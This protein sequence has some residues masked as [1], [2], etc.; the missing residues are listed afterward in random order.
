MSQLADRAP[1]CFIAESFALSN[2]QP[3]LVSITEEELLRI[4]ASLPI[5]LN[6][7]ELVTALE[8]AFGSASFSRCSSSQNLMTVTAFR[9]CRAEAIELLAAEIVVL[10]DFRS[11]VETKLGRSLCGVDGT[12]AIRSGLAGV[13][14]CF[15][16]I[17]SVRDR[18]I[19]GYGNGCQYGDDLVTSDVFEKEA[20][21]EEL[22]ASLLL[23]LKVVLLTGFIR[24]CK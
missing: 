19:R 21:W 23:L 13:D 2:E 10:L 20:Q 14:A 6:P 17:K 1:Y 3:M 12:I 9:V 8:N 15:R 18:A 5:P 7:A 16:Y 22:E 24:I 4:P 11:R